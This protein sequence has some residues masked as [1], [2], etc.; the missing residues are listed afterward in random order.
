VI[1]APKS[2]S[3]VTSRPALGDLL[4]ID[5]KRLA[6]F[7]RVG[8]R[9]TGDR[10]QYT[11]KAGWEYLFVAVDDH[12]RTAFTRLYPDERRE[13]AI[14]FLQA[15]TDYFKGLGARIARLIT[16]NGPAFRS[17]EL[18]QTCQALQIQQ[19]FTRAYRPQTNG[20]AERFIQSALHE[21]ACGHAYPNSSERGAALAQWNHF[22]N[23][24]RPHHSIGC[25]VPMDQIPTNANNVLTLHS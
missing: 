23:W 8:H 9:I 13:S 1:C 6:R 18:A 7:E 15:T 11:A 10:R 22:Y 12:S 21:W 19:R 3:P 14:A 20:K 24:H 5:I 4:H 25:R 2:P 16:D 17:H